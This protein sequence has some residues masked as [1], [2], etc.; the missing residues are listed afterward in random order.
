[1]LCLRAHSVLLV[2]PVVLSPLTVLPKPPAAFK[3]RFSRA[4][5]GQQHTFQ[6]AILLIWTSKHDICFL[7]FFLTF[8]LTFFFFFHNSMTHVLW[9]TCD[10]SPWLVFHRLSVRSIIPAQVSHVALVPA[11]APFS[12]FSRSC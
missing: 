7:L 3:W 11:A 2:L 4:Y 9:V 8:F 1:M 10:D 12:S 5:T 6:K